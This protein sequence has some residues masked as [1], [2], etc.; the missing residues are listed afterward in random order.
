[1][2]FILG[3]VIGNDDVRPTLRKVLAALDS[4][5]DERLDD[6]ADGREQEIPQ[7]ETLDRPLRCAVGD[8]AA[9]AGRVTIA[10]TWSK[11]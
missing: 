10:R 11:A 3:D 6:R 8:H 4:N 5:V 1:M 9:G 7:P 2:V